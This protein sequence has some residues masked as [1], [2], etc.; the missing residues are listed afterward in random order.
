MAG[1]S[2]PEKKLTAQPIVEFM[3]AH[4]WHCESLEV[5]TTFGGVPIGTPGRADWLFVRSLDPNGVAALIFCECK[6]PNAVM[7]C[8]CRPATYGQNAKG[9]MVQ[10]KRAHKCRMCA[11]AEFRDAMRRKGF[12]CVQFAHAEAYKAWFLENFRWTMQSSLDLQSV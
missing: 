12:V 4:G 5:G 11:Q 6:A 10:K 8:N 3:R 1:H 2:A 7:R 9:R